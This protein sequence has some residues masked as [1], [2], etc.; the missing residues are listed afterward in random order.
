MGCERG[1]PRLAAFFRRSKDTL[2]DSFF[3]VFLP[4]AAEYCS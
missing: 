4:D 2:N 1:W 3:P